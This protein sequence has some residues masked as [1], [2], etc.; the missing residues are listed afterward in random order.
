MHFSISPWQTYA[1]CAW[2]AARRQPAYRKYYN[3]LDK[4]RLPTAKTLGNSDFLA[5]NDAFPKAKDW[6]LLYPAN[7]A[8]NAVDANVF[9]HPDCFPSVL[10]FHAVDT[11]II[12]PKDGLIGMDTFPAQKCYYQD[13]NGGSHIRVL[14]ENF[15]FQLRSETAKIEPENAYIGLEI[16]REKGFEKRLKRTA[17]LFAIKGGNTPDLDDLHRPKRPELHADSLKIYDLRQAG[18][19]WK[20]AILALYGEDYLEKNPDNFDL[21]KQTVRNYYRRAERHVQG[22][23]LKILRRN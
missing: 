11:D 7:P 1:G 5:A 10:R 13:E 21:A 20:E 14:G 18:G 3:S 19:T 4:S 23:F 6:G 9:W 16:N 17:E 2:E 15:W 8:L 12:S 22:G